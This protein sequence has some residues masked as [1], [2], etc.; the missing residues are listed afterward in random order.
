VIHW[1]SLLAARGSSQVPQAVRGHEATKARQIETKRF[2]EEFVASLRSQ[3]LIGKPRTFWSFGT[4]PAEALSPWHGSLV[5]DTYDLL[6]TRS[7]D[8]EFDVDSDPTAQI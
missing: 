5:E 7:R 4:V 1:L 6:N 2:M 8:K 3:Q